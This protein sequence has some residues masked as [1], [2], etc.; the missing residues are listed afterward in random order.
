MKT[1]LIIDADIIRI[2]MVPENE[3]DKNIIAAVG[4][5]KYEVQIYTGSMSQ[6]AGGWDKIGSADE[7]MIL[8]MI[9][10]GASK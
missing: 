7:G 4:K 8:R 5:E 10:N 1:S 6:T 9:K 3:N 2:F